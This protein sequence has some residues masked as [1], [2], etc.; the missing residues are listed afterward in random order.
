MWKLAWCVARPTRS[1]VRYS[2]LTLSTA[3]SAVAVG[4]LLA[5]W[6]CRGAF[7]S[8]SLQGLGVLEEVVLP[9]F[10][11]VL[12]CADAVEKL[13]QRVSVF[14]RDTEFELRVVD[15]FQQLGTV[16]LGLGHADVS[17]GGGAFVVLG[18]LRGF[19]QR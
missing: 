1:G 18:E 6:P 9:R 15:D 13:R 5:V 8:A 7:I 12:D 14:R 17:V 10:R 19:G 2:R 3:S 11:L 16:D 4:R